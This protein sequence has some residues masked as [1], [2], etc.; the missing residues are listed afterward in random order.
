MR[1]ASLSWGL[2]GL[3]LVLIGCGFGL[4]YGR[5]EVLAF[6]LALALVLGVSLLEAR[7]LGRRLRV[8]RT[9][10]PLAE[11]RVVE[12]GLRL[13]NDGWLPL[14][15]LILRDI[16]P[17]QVPTTVTLGIFPGLRAGGALPLSYRAFL[18]ATRGRYRVGPVTAQVYGPLGFAS[19]S[20]VL[21]PP[22]EATVYPRGLDVRGLLVPA[23]GESAWAG[24]LSRQVG[25]SVVFR[26]VRE[27]Q[28]GD[29]PR[30]V[31]WRSTARHGRLVV[32]EFEALRSSQALLL[33][34]F[35]RFARLGVGRRGTVEYA[36]RLASALAE[37]LFRRNRAV[38]LYA[39]DDR[40]LRVPP[41]RSR[42][43]LARLRKALA[44]ARGV[45]QEPFEQVLRRG[46][47]LVRGGLCVPVLLRRSADPKRILPPLLAHLR[48]GGQLLCVLL[49]ARGFVPIF[50]EQVDQARAA[51]A[52]LL[53]ILSAAG[54]SVVC[55]GTDMRLSFVVGGRR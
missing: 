8:E 42:A 15:P 45:G 41:S 43:M 7:L 31:H 46:L 47:A 18:N 27:Y 4:S 53:S 30:A 17:P 14:P 23:A 9:L 48:A 35:H 51:S 13:R 33:V 12:V 34:D 38:G 28:P 21:C 29:P 36:V 20:H 40:V 3:G 52:D 32:R 11:D 1:K 55:V 19:Q 37:E 22:G 50:Q 49:E 24:A 44:E 39:V 16:F 5:P 6:G 2:A 10:P 54:A 26:G 25:D